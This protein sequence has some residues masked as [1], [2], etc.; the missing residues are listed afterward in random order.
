[1]EISDV[2]LRPAAA[3]GRVRAMAAIVIDGSFVVNDLRVVEGPRGLFVSM[4][5]RRRAAGG[6]Y[7]IAHP[8][9]PEAH[10]CIQQAVLDAYARWRQRAAGGTV[11]AAG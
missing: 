7:D 1:M 10:A 8:I 6:Y 11:E 9:T 3:P 2:R 5:S 4:P